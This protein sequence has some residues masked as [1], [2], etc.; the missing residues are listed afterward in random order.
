MIELGISLSLACAFLTNVSG[1]CKHRG[2]IAAPAVSFRHPARSAASLFRSRWWTIGFAV[3]A[4]AWVLHVAALAIAPLSLVQMLISGGLVLLAFPAER[5]FGLKLGPRQWAGLG[6]SAGGLALLALSTDT[7]GAHASYSIPSLAAFEAGAIG[8][9][10]VLLLG[11]RSDSPGPRHG[12]ALG[13]AAGLLVGVSDVSIKALTGTVP[14]DPISILGPWTLV[15]LVAGVLAFFALARGF[16]TGEAIQVITLSSVAA[17]CSAILGGVLVFGD[18]MGN[19]TLEIVARSLAFA[20]VITAA[21]L[22]P[23]PR[24][25]QPASA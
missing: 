13:A 14:G 1:L 18:P 11:G 24:S 17:N 7:S 2:A 12:A 15:A 10:V 20:A 21:A 4:G 6:L 9:G 3:A 22:M 16:Q 8:I 5:W 25:A 19:G 23:A